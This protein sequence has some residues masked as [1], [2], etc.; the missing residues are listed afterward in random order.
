MKD[1]LAFSD[2]EEEGNIEVP[3]QDGG[4][5]PPMATIRTQ[6]QDGLTLSQEHTPLFGNMAQSQGLPSQQFMPMQCLSQLLQ[7]AFC[8]LNV[9]RC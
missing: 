3:T 7:P 9:V 5:I 4:N 2:D 6:T 8:I 1:L